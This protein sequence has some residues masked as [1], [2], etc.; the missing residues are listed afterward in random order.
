GDL[1]VELEDGSKVS[2]T[3]IKRVGF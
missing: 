2:M 3:Q 1:Q